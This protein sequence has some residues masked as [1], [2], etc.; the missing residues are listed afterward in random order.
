MDRAG[1][2][3]GGVALSVDPKLKPE[4]TPGWRCP[5]TFRIWFSLAYRMVWTR[6][7]RYGRG[8]GLAA[9]FGGKDLT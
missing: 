8:P 1:A 3:A 2:G 9:G 4:R 7:E 6:V 5:D